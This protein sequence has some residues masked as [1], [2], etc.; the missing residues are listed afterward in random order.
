MSEEYRVTR[1]QIVEAALSFRNVKFRHQGRSA[2]TG[3]DCVGFL[4]VILT[5]LNYP[6]IVDVEGYRH[7]PSATVIHQT[8]CQNFD[9]IPVAEVGLGDIYLMRIGGRK[10]KHASILINDVRDVAK[11]IEPEIIH[12]Y[13]MGDTGRVTID[14]LATWLPW[15]VTAFRLRGL[16]VN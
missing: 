4:H 14:A 6:V 11:G 3:V 2:E 16:E 10:P 9:E 7:S 1:S 12:A 5:K 15:C 8:M 13:G